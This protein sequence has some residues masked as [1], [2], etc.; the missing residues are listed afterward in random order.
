MN[1]VI[2]PDATPQEREE[3]LKAKA[4]KTES[5]TY[6]R[7]LSPNEISVEKH[8][9]AQDAIERDS[10][11]EEAKQHADDYKARITALEDKMAEC[12]GK[13][14]HGKTDVTGWL[15]GIVNH[16]EKLM[17]FYDKYGELIN[18]RELLPEEAQGHLFV[19]PAASTAKKPGDN[20]KPLPAAKQAAL[21]AQDGKNATNQ[22]IVRPDGMKDDEWIAFEAQKQKE[23]AALAAGNKGATKSTSHIDKTGLQKEPVKTQAELQKENANKNLAKGKPG[24]K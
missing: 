12:L 9:Y 23:F 18:S 17:A 14:K 11:K 10:L 24:G 21:P 8:R 3:A 19:D 4:V 6:P 7:T 22:P 5:R 16:D 15:Y 2:F 13:V 1:I 20:T